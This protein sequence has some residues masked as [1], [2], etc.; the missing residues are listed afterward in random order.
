MHDHLHAFVSNFIRRHRRDRVLWLIS[1]RQDDKRW[2]QA[3]FELFRF[4][5][6]R[7]DTRYATRLTHKQSEPSGVGELLRKAGAPQM[8]Y[9]LNLYA[10]GQPEE[11]ELPLAEALAVPWFYGGTLISCIPGALVFLNGDVKGDNFLF[12]KMA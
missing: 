11:A 12:Q 3:K 10:P 7:H 8:C 2:R 6:D 9:R 5:A 1:K 4:S